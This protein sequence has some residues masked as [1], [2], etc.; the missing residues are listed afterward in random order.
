MGIAGRII[1]FLLLFV[2][3]G[4]NASG[5]DSY[6]RR[7]ISDVKREIDSTFSTKRNVDIKRRGYK[8]FKKEIDSVF[9]VKK[10]TDEQI[11]RQYRNKINAEY[12]ES[13]MEEWSTKESEPEVP[14][15]QEEPV[16]PVQP[17]A[18]ED[19]NSYSEVTEPLPYK[20]V[21]TPPEPIQQPQPVVPIFEIPDLDTEW[22]DFEFYGTK[23]QVR[24]DERHSFTLPS[25]EP[26]A[27]SEQ[28][29]KCSEELYDNLI[30]DC[31]KLRDKMNL[32]D[33]AYL[34]ML[35]VLCDEFLGEDTNE[36]VFLRA[37]I[38]CQSGYKMRFGLSADNKQLLMAF[39]SHHLIYTQN[40]IGN[41]KMT[42]TQSTLPP[43]V[44]LYDCEVSSYYESPAIFENEQPLSLIVD[45]APLFAESDTE[46]RK[47][48][49]RRY[50][51]M[52]FTASENKNL[53]DFYATYPPSTH[54]NNM[55]TQWSIYANA[56][57]SETVKE[58]LYEPMK[59][60][61]EGLSPYDAVSYLLN[62]AQTGFE[63]KLDSEVW[64][65]ERIFFMEET[66]Y[67]PYSDCE[68]RSILLARVVRDLLGLDVILLKYPSHL[69]TAIAIPG[70]VSGAYYEH[71]GKNYFVCDPTCLNASV[72]YLHPDYRGCIPHLIEV[73]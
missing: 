36:S 37:F 1:L 2:S 26:R 16:F 35:D 25:L 72:G 32:C 20:L 58:N 24:L 52:S 50:I 59:K 60:S 57:V 9:S 49:S 54:S 27:L 62:W 41:V 43:Y 6:K 4:V 65:G 34:Q 61:L 66:L 48:E 14:M 8:D 45:S 12:A 55:M 42:K 47:I 73:D 11:F 21:I 13:L 33:F 63:Y 64:G 67:Y 39:S 15:P 30:V 69:S 71:K 7:A 17:V 19:T 70:E 53:M 28:W 51:N 22:F 18:L 23:C 10:E 29:K 38:Y 44:Y 3:V 68:D 46:E 40:L 5:S 56:P 31:L